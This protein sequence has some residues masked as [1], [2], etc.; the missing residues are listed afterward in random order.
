MDAHAVADAPETFTGRRGVHTVAAMTALEAPVRARL[1][2]HV[3]LAVR[4][5]ALA[6]PTLGR[7][8]TV[9]L[10]ELAT[11]VRCVVSTSLAVVTQQREPSAG[12][13]QAWEQMGQRAAQLGVPIQDVTQALRVGCTTVWEA[14]S[15]AATVAGG[16]APFDLLEQAPRLWEHFDVMASVVET[17]HRAVGTARDIEQSQRACAFFRAL[18]GHS[19]IDG[20]AEALARGLGLDPTGAF[21]AVVHS[22]DGVHPQPEGPFVVAEEPDRTVVLLQAGA[23][24]GDAEARAVADLH[25][26]GASAAGVGVQRAGLGGAAQSLQDAEAAYRAAAVLGERVVS[27]RDSW[28][29]CLVIQHREQHETLVAAAVTCLRT[30][31]Q[32][33]QTVAAFLDAEGSLPAAA[34]MLG[35]HANT[36]AYRLRQ[37]AERSGLDART[38][39]GLALARLALTFAL[40]ETASWTPPL[41]RAA[42]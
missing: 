2:D 18:R 10:R 20:D 39:A 17:A 5:V 26:G 40:A 1:D 27:F 36:V 13:L 29:Q 16:Q 31:E 34:A 28:L 8:S 6:V 35:L 37:L 3:D 7:G 14:L 32:M 19:G 33:R 42:S 22:S 30:D 24:P 9:S 21:V 25:A 12:E 15:Q 38:A 11:A 4:H 23:E 41:R